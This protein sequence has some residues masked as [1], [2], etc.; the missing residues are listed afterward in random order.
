MGRRTSA[1][2]LA[3]IAATL[4]GCWQDP[5]SSAGGAHQAHDYIP[6][7]ARALVD[8]QGAADGLA[9]AQVGLSS[10]VVIAAGPPPRVQCGV[11]DNAGRFGAVTFD[12]N[13]TDWQDD[14]CVNLVS[15][16]MNGHVLYVNST[17]APVAAKALAHAGHRRHRR[18]GD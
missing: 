8:A 11:A 12:A 5:A 9:G 2:T 16:V 7:C 3:A 13:C 6:L 10:P 4:T 17:L 15:A 1:A 14:H 18:A